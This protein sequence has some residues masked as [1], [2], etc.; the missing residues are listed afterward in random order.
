MVKRRARFFDVRLRVRSLP[1]LDERS[2]CKE[3]LSKGKEENR[4][5]PECARKDA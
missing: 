1:S 3:K 5:P 4:R 2:E